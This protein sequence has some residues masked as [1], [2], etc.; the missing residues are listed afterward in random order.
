VVRLAVLPAARGLG[1]GGA[2]IEECLRRARESGATTLALHTTEW[3]TVARA[4]YERMGFLRA[5]EFDFYPRSGVVGLG[6]RHDL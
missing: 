6:Y 1:I 4:M 3:M 2:L 5:P